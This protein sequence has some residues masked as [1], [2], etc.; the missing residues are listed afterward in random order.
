MTCQEICCKEFISVFCSFNH[1]G[2]LKASSACD[3]SVSDLDLR[4]VYFNVLTHHSPI[5]G[6]PDLFNFTSTSALDS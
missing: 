3:L 5:S 6:F 4:L 1:S 2:N